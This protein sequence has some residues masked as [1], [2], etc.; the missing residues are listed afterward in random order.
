MAMILDQDSFLA[1]KSELDLFSVPPTQ[2]AIEKGSWF[3]IYPKNTVTRDGPYEFSLS[4]DPWYLDLNR[5]LLHMVL[6]L[7]KKDGSALEDTTDVAFINLIGKC[8]IKQCKVWLNNKLAYDSS[9]TYAYRA[10]LETLLNYGSDAKASHL[11]AGMYYRDTPSKMDEAQNEG[12]KNRLEFS[13]GSRHVELMAPI[14]ADPF[15]QDRF[16]LNNMEVRLELHRN[17]D[18]FCLNSFAAEAPD[19]QINV[20]SMVWYVRKVDILKSLALSLERY[21]LTHTAKFPVR[22]VVVKTLHIDGGRKDSPN[23]VIFTGQIPRRMIVGCVDKDAYHGAL[24]KSPFNFKNFSIRQVRVTAGGLTYPRNPMPLD[25][26]N[27][28]YT[29]AFL[30]LFDSLN[31]INEDRSN[32]IGYSDYHTGYCL[33]G[34]DLS[35]DSTDGSHWELV[36]SGSTSLHIDFDEDTPDTGIK[37]LI[38]G[39]FDGVMSVDRY[40]N[41][42]FDYTV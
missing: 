39:E 12:H 36:S 21:L 24:K 9:D 14:H 6:S 15:L 22:R 27:R 33:F 42:F 16:L 34:I 30:S 38:L 41:C 2:V 28:R 32:K 5:N 31:L 17:S 13:K 11:Q 25:F 19:V 23:N 35:A 40:R 4:G 1:T 20:V 10:Y 7:T 26:K 3:E 18:N 8:F 29:R 37:V